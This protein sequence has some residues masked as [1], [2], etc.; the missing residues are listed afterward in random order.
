VPA[1][2][3]SL[4]AEAGVLERLVSW[5]KAE[6]AIRALVLTSSRARRD[7]TVDLLSDYDVIL[8][9]RDPAEFPGNGDWATAYGL[10]L[11]A[12]G[13]ESE[14]DGLTTRFWGVVYEDGVKVDY[15]IWP[16]ELLERVAERDRLPDDLDVG[17]R[18]LL[19]KDGACARWQ[20]PTQRAHV[21]TRPT[22]AEYDALVEEFWWSTT[23]VAKALWRGEV[24]FAKFALDVDAKLVALRRFLE[25]RI[26][27]DHGWSLRPGAYGRG[28]E[29]LLPPELWAELA[30][31]YVGT[32]VEDN[33]NALFRTAALFRR[34]AT[35]VGD[36]L[37]FAYPQ[38]VDDAVTAQL[39]AVR[40]LPP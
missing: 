2:I 36:A 1:P 19:D 38:E 3:V 14:L 31:T 33:W 20:A 9:V 39:R 40:R 13:D 28:L 7:E 8:A 4:P 11:A 34:V 6:E 30:A 16:V 29:R 17:Y 12:W 27:L 15:T 35:E 37:G 5:G 10:P 23:Y 24:V 22:R 21:P 26:E 18:V 32:D 25:W